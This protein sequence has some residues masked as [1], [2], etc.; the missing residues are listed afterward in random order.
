[1]SAAQLTASV[2]SGR[3]KQSLRGVHDDQ[4]ALQAA[5]A[6]LYRGERDSALRDRYLHDELIRYLGVLERKR[7]AH[8]RDI[9]NRVIPSP[10]EDGV[11]LEMLPRQAASIEIFLRNEHRGT[12]NGRMTDLCNRVLVSTSPSFGPG[13]N[14]AKLTGANRCCVSEVEN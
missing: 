13:A 5:R 4:A 1:M 9:V 2:R 14:S 10:N 12:P 8:T 6:K 3:I 7:F 11:Y